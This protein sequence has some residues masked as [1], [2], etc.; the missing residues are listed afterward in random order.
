MYMFHHL[1]NVMGVMPDVNWGRRFYLIKITFTRRLM[2]KLWRVI[3]MKNTIINIPEPVQW[4]G[5]CPHN[6]LQTES[7]A[8]LA[9]S[10]A[11]VTITKQ[12]KPS[13][14]VEVFV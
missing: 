2:G 9:Q 5:G 8:L 14:P 7:Q 12:N 1:E 4:G 3:S 10:P 11:C 6:R 13:A